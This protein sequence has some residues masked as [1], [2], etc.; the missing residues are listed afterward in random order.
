M[1][2]MCCTS[3]KYHSYYL[4]VKHYYIIEGQG[5]CH[6]H[7]FPIYSK[8]FM[9]IQHHKTDI[10]AHK[11]KTLHVLYLIKWVEGCSGSVIVVS[12]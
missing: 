6:V 12:G 5:Y 1:M 7:E 9:T 4:L 8:T 2:R 3:N 11:K 10:D